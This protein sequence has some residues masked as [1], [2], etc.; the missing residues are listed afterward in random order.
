M[1][2]NEVIERLIKGNEQYLKN[3][4]NLGDTSA[5]IRKKTAEEGQHPYAIVIACSDSRVIPEAIF[6]ANL[7]DLF[8]IRIAGNVL[9]NHQLGSIE[10]AASHLDANV[11]VMLGHT[12]CG[13]VAAAIK[14]VNEGFIKYITDDI[15]KTI[16]AETDDYKATTLNV[17]HG[18]SRIRQAFKEHPEIVSDELE[19]VGAVYN[20]DTGKVDWV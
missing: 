3:R 11:I 16:G 9:D 1:N 8:V 5:E 20:L 19:I 13:A 14:G 17:K 12:R 15:S 10:Y 7:G 2:N 18:V 4:Y 6:S